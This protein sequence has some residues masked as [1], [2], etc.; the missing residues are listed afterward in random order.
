[1]FTL[2][3]IWNIII[4]TVVFFVAAWYIRQKLES[5]GLEKSMMRGL[6]VFLLAYIVS[7]GAGA[8]IDKVHDKIYGAPPPSQVEQDLKQMLKDQGLTVPNH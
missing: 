6:L 8:I 1:M 7:W 2:P 5:F 3:S 4:S